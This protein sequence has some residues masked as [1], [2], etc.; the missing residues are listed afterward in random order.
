[1]NRVISAETQTL[2]IKEFL[3]ILVTE[4][5]NCFLKFYLVFCKLIYVQVEKLKLFSQIIYLK[6]NNVLARTKGY[7]T[8][9]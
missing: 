3:I 8:S 5:C 9:K 7:N 2:K 4:K 1:M 6:K